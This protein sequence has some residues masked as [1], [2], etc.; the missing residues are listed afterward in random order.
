MAL[1]R[2]ARRR[3]VR[4]P[5]VGPHSREAAWP[6]GPALGLGVQVVLTRKVCPTQELRAPRPRA[7]APEYREG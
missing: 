5:T 7:L 2:L 1:A 4:P 3:A 6:V